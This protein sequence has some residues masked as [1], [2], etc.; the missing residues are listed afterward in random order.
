MEGGHDQ[1]GLR[2][3]TDTIVPVDALRYYNNG[4]EIRLSSQGVYLTVGIPDG[5]GG[6]HVPPY[7]L[8]PCIDRVTGDVVNTMH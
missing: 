5:Q 8:L 6:T 4:G 7:C 1:S 2:G 3:G